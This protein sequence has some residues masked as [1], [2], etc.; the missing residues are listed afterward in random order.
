MIE[1][2]SK[3]DETKQEMMKMN[4]Q[5]HVMGDMSS[6]SGSPPPPTAS[7]VV[8]ATSVESPA[9]SIEDQNAPVMLTTMQPVPLNIMD[10]P[11]DYMP[12]TYVD[13]GRQHEFIYQMD[14]KN[15]EIVRQD[16]LPPGT[17]SVVVQQPGGVLPTYQTPGTTVLVLSELVEDIPTVR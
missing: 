15:V 3:M 12:N 10:M 8:V 16:D 17:V 9:G 4:R 14:G 1:K 6:P 2:D 5:T 13:D 11:K 7:P